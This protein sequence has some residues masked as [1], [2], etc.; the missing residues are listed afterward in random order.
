MLFPSSGWAMLMPHT[1]IQTPRERPTIGKRVV[2]DNA[3][4]LARQ[5][6]NTS[7]CVVPSDQSLPSTDQQPS[8]PLKTSAMLSVEEIWRPR[9]SRSPILEVVAAI[10]SRNCALLDCHCCPPAAL[11]L[12][13]PRRCADALEYRLFQPPRLRVFRCGR[14]ESS[15]RAPCE[16]DVASLCSI[17]AREPRMTQSTERDASRGLRDS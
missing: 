13:S 4:Y 9:W 11:R 16:V 5:R 10:Y 17:T 14:T 3:S 8:R 7:S 1:G 6:K 2:L 12:R 15:R